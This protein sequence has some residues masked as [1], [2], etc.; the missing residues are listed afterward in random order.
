MPL[1]IKQYLQRLKYTGNTNPTPE[2][3]FALQETHLMSVPFENLDIHNN[4]KIDLTNLYDKIVIR[5]RGGFCYE[6]NGLFYEL[7]KALGFSVKMV[8]ARVFQGEKGFG[9]EFDHM[10][11]IV[12]FGNDEYLA[13]VGFGEFTIKPLKIE[14]DKE[15]KDP[16]G[17]FRI[18]KY[19]DTYNVVK[20]KDESGNYL[21]RYIFSDTE[22]AIDDFREMCI[23]HQTSS[24]SHF[25][26]NKICSLP[27]KDGRITLS[28]KKLITTTGGKAETRELESD[29]E[30]KQVLKT[31]FGIMTI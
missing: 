9:A 21:P 15:I 28:G 16:L 25:T 24:E 8:S 17:V 31:Q 20:Q 7:L 26:Q 11:L 23:F 3:L 22:R 10:A 29:E 19:D 14:F 27:M 13:D 12:R 30:V 6:L 18:E 4:V 2:T 1:D 5:N